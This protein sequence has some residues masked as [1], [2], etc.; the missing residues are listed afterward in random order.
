MFTLADFKQ[1]KKTSKHVLPQETL[2]I[3]AKISKMIGI[4]PQI[5]VFKVEKVYTIPQQITI[6]LN[7][8]SEDNYKII[9]DKIIKL[10][11]SNPSEI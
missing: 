5:P 2:D 8:F 10:I 7:K 3:I 9:E 6:L 1:I 4:E 11:E